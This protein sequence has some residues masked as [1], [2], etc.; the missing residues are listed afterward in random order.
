MKTAKE[1]RGKPWKDILVSLQNTSRGIM[2]QENQNRDP[3][4]VFA[5]GSDSQSKH[6]M[7]KFLHL[8]VQTGLQ[9]ASRR[10]GAAT[11]SNASIIDALQPRVT[12]ALTLGVVIQGCINF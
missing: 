3:G 12:H 10:K 7:H 4:F 11:Q 8:R 5:V 1:G 9:S 6:E 2:K